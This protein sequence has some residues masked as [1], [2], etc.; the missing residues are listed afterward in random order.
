MAFGQHNG[1]AISAQ[2]STRREI[3]FAV[4]RQWMRFEIASVFNSLNANNRVACE[5]LR[6]AGKATALRVITEDIE[7][8]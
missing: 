4:E 6:A 2:K 3:L 1:K 8:V 7:D 5:K